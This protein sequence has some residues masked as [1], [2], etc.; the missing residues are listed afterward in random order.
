VKSLCCEST[1]ERIKLYFLK[2]DVVLTE[3]ENQVRCRWQAA[4]SM[5]INQNGIER[6]VVKMLMKTYDISEVQAYRDVHDCT[7]CFGPVRGVDRQSLRNMLTQWAIEHLRKASHL[8]DFK[9]V[10]KFMERIQKVNNLDKEDMELPDP[11]KIQ[12]PVQLL[13]IN[14]NFLNTE[15][16]KL[17]D[18]KAQQEL[19]KLNAKVMALIESSPIANYKNILLADDAIAED[20]AD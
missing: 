19:L 15:Y 13:S 4:Y 3:H 10:D 14:Y 6:E 5:L 2:E 8:N 9:S 17:I 16:F 12:P 11:S 18:P 20:I 7:R 1:L